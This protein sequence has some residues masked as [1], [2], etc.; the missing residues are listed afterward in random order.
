MVL[1]CNFDTDKKLTGAPKESASAS[2]APTWSEE[3][4]TMYRELIARRREAI[5]DFA[6]TPEEESGD[7]RLSGIT[8]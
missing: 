7:N 4:E 3:D 6:K 8:R 2:T 1:V 5:F